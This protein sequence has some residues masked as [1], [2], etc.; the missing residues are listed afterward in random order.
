MRSRIARIITRIIRDDDLDLYILAAA[1]FT[2]TILGTVGIY[3]VAVL[4]SV[5]LAVLAF[6]ALSQIRTRR[7]V[8]Q[9]AS[10]HIG[11]RLALLGEGFPEDLALRRANA[12]DY[13]F[14]GVSMRR[15]V[16][17]AGADIRRSLAAGRTVRVLLIDPANDSLLQQAVKRRRVIR[18]V[19]RLRRTITASFDE[20]KALGDEVGGS[21][22]LRVSHLLPTMGMH[23]IDSEAADGLVCLQHYE[24]QPEREANPVIRLNASDGFWYRYFVSE[25]ERLWADGTPLGPGSLNAAAQGL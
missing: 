15:T 10:A 13:L 18:D 17:S 20:L 3:D 24:Y 9:I 5:N 12:K 14:I 6:L 21:L 11:G 7:H 8:G 4:S 23:V 19:D 1:A 16:P 25:A 22:S 2:F